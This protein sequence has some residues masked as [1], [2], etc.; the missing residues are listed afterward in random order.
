MVG[1]RELPSV[2]VGRG[3][4]S[5]V[6]VAAVVVAVAASRIVVVVDVAAEALLPFGVVVVAAV[7]AVASSV[8]DVALL[9]GG[10]L[11]PRPWRPGNDAPPRLRARPLLVSRASQRTWHRPLPFVPCVWRRPVAT[12]AEDRCDVAVV[13]AVV[14]ELAAEQQ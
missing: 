1:G 8:V 3:F 13:L 4:E 11:P 2:V 10:E 7:V 5:V 9:A 6:V 12:R 14:V